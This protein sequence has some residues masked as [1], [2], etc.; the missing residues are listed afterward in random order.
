M[1]ADELDVHKEKRNRYVDENIWE[2]RELYT[3]EEQKK[4]NKG[5]VED[6]K[7]ILIKLYEVLELSSTKSSSFIDKE[8]DNLLKYIK[9]IRSPTQT[10]IL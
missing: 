9:F 3:D 1:L 6:E 7:V 10:R 8:I 2:I 5:K 4:K